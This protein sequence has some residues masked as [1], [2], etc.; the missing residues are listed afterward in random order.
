METHP[1]A[2]LPAQRKSPRFAT[3]PTDEGGQTANA[4]SDP[5][6]GKVK[7]VET[8]GAPA[9]EPRRTCNHSKQEN[10]TTVGPEVKLAVTGIEFSN[11]GEGILVIDMS[12]INT[13]A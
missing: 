3:T 6:N 9:P 5:V 11:T 10:K 8:V 2:I 7:D 4:P 1:V 12:T 13:Y